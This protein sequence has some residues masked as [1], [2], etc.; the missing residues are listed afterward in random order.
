MDYTW[1]TA[2]NPRFK[3]ERDHTLMQGHEYCN[4]RYLQIAEKP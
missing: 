1:P 2:F 4:H 3:M